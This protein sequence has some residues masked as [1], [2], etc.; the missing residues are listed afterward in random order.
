MVFIVW[1]FVTFIRQASGIWGGGG[2]GM[3]Q[4][5]G[6]CVFIWWGWGGEVSGAFII[7]G[8]G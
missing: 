4:W 3:I 5:S 7:G 1:L 8:L 6:F 2:G